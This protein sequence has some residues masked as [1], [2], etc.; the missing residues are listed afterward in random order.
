[1]YELTILYYICHGPKSCGKCEEH[2]PGFL[3]EHS[4]E[5]STDGLNK[6]TI[7]AALADCPAGAL[8]LEPVE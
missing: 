8:Q 2:I 7:D 6:E 1:M 4:G 3:S 5:M